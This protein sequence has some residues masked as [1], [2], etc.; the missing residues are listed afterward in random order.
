MN[1]PQP[2]PRDSSDNS[3]KLRRIEAIHVAISEEELDWARKILSL[4]QVGMVRVNSTG[5]HESTSTDLPTVQKSND[6][7][8]QIARS[9]EKRFLR[10]LRLQIESNLGEINETPT[11]GESSP[12]QGIHLTENSDHCD[13]KISGDINSDKDV[14]APVMNVNAGSHQMNPGAEDNFR[15]EQSMANVADHRKGDEGGSIRMT[16]VLHQD[17]NQGN[18]HTSNQIMQPLQQEQEKL[19]IRDFTDAKEQGKLQENQ[20]IDTK[21]TQEAQLANDEAHSETSKDKQHGNGE[22][23]KW[24][25]KDTINSNANTMQQ[26]NDKGRIQPGNTN[27]ERAG[28]FV[29]FAP[30][31]ADHSDTSRNKLHIGQNELGKGRVVVTRKLSKRGSEDKIWG[32]SISMSHD[33]DPKILPPPLKVS[34]NFDS[35][36]PNQPITNQTSPKQ[37]QHKPIVN[38]TFIK[39]ANQQIPD[40]APPLSSNP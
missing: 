5:Y 40:P 3:S 10:K 19:F 18:E 23:T 39:N 27:K 6:S 28:K 24:K 16:S 13:G 12:G 30:N 11:T 20:E 14:G 7:I 21:G 26:S 35:Y 9:T 22:K 33:I 37:N 4:E 2:R 32:T 31:V 15:K 25:V 29:N 36:R 8:A 1:K 17:H 34:S 38:S